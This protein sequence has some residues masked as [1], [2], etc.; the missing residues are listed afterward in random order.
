LFHANVNGPDWIG[1][2]PQ[3]SGERKAGFY[4]QKSIDN[5]ALLQF[6]DVPPA[7]DRPALDNES[8]VTLS[9]DYGGLDLVVCLRTW[10]RLVLLLPFIGAS[11]PLLW[12]IDGFERE[13]PAG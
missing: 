11:R 2:I 5:A 1:A 8:S 6:C 10:R 4:V 12:F 7:R 13:F 9:C 3:R